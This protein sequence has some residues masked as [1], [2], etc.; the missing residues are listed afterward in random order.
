MLP[1]LLIAL[2]YLGAMGGFYAYLLLTAQAQPEA[3]AEPTYREAVVISSGRSRREERLV[4]D[5]P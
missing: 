4:N 5:R 3:M 1:F 2:I